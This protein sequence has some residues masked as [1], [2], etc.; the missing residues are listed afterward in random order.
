MS[1]HYFYKE[2]NLTSIILLKT[3]KV[4]ELIAAREGI[5]FES[6]LEKFLDSKTYESLCNPDTLLWSES[7]PFILDDYLR[8]LSVS[9]R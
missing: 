9:G 6:A 7:S 8:E 3:E 2:K 1:Q 4:V 5:D